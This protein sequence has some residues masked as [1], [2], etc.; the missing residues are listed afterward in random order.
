[1]WLDLWRTGLEHGRASCGRQFADLG[2]RAQVL[3]CC[4]NAVRQLATKPRIRSGRKH[5]LAAEM[6]PSSTRPP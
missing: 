2:E 4:A 5:H 6:L 1:M 3:L